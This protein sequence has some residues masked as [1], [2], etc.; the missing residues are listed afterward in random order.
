MQWTA[1]KVQEEIVQLLQPFNPKGIE[2]TSGTDLSADLMMPGRGS[3][4]APGA[5]P[6]RLG[7]VAIPADHPR[8]RG[9]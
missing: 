7:V 3:Y 4:P 5:L 6:D 9:P 1:D 8:S 2:I